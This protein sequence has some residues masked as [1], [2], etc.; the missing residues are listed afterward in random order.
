MGFGLTIDRLQVR[1]ATQC[2]IPWLT[3][4]TNTHRQLNIVVSL[5]NAQTKWFSC[6]RNRLMT[7]TNHN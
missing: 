7:L 6:N 2:A 5:L 4:V 1:R 3:R